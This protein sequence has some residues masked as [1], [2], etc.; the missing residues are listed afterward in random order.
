M[1][2]TNDKLPNHFR[3]FIHEL[4]E[5]HVEYLII[6][7]YALGAYGHIRATADLDIFINATEVNA[8]KLISACSKYG[9]PTEYLKKE[10]FL[11]PKMVGIGEPPMRIEILK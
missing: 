8:L 6:G 5:H 9:I 2:P 11:V 7:E 10:M 3:D 4:N 1:S